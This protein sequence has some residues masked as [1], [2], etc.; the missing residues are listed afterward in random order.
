MS[1]RDE[2]IYLFCSSRPWGI[3]EFLK[4]RK[5]FPGRWFI[6][7][8]KNDLEEICEKLA[9]K[10]RYAF[11]PHWS[12]IVPKRVIEN[13]ECVCF[14]M[15]DLPYG[16]GGSPLQNLI[17]RG[18]TKTRLSA[19]RMTEELD[20]GPIYMKRDLDLSGSAREIFLRAT[21]IELEM[22]REIIENQP[23]P[24]PQEGEPVVFKRRKPSQ[25]VLP[26]KGALEH[27]YDF[28][29]ML[30]APGYPHAFVDHGAFRFEFTD[31]EWKGKEIV[32]RAVIRK[33]ND[34]E[35]EE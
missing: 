29:R 7:C 5:Q 15:T 13:I 27:V 28:I 19:L 11:F 34:G 18:H 23:T 22:I 9:Y 2:N 31:A 26:E 32:A 8:D 35:G 20:A 1:D 24:V 21:K 30:D 33:R 4:V 14:H 17:V 3:E 25:S 16:R 10:V 12:H 6:V